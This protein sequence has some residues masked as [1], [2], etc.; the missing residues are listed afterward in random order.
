MFKGIGGC[1]YLNSIGVV[2]IVKIK[3]FDIVKN[4]DLV[5]MFYIYLGFRVISGIEVDIGF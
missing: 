4:D 2:F 1:V 5:F 3:F